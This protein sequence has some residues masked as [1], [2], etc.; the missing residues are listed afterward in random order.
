MKNA[1]DNHNQCAVDNCI[2]C[3]LKGVNREYEELIDQIIIDQIVTFGKS[4]NPIGI[5][6]EMMNFVY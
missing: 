4:Y 5:L 1:R 6:E 3:S 2:F